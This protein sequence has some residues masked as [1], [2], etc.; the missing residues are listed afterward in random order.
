MS[1]DNNKNRDV[2]AY[3]MFSLLFDDG[4]FTEFGTKVM[5]CDNLAEGIIACGKV[6][7]RSV[8]AFAQDTGSCGG[9]LSVAQANKFKK[10]YSLALKTGYPIVGIYSDSTA[11]VTQGNMLLDAVG[12]VL[13][14]SSRLSGVVPMVSLVLGS[15][16]GVSA[17][18]ASNADFVVMTEDAKLSVSDCSL[19]SGKGK[20]AYVAKDAESAAKAVA[21]LV[22]YLPSNNL[23]VAPLA[24]NFTADTDSVFD[25]DSVLRLYTEKESAASVALARLAGK[26]VGCVKTTGQPIDSKSC[27]KIAAFVRF[28]DAYSIPVITEVNSPEFECLGGAKTVLSAY[29][30]ATTIKISVITGKAVGVGYLALAGKGARADVILA[31]Q[32]AV[33]SPVKP[34]VAAFIALG[35]KLDVPVAQQDELISQYIAN[36]L[37]AENAAKE[38]FIDNALEFSALRDELINY[39]EILSGKRESSLP[40]KHNTI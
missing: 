40:K 7:G 19:C 4:N 27:K 39:L 33:I 13:C 25:K 26:V 24:E 16:I 31:T 15:C 36:E 22:S 12:D 29:S 37:S 32:G 1:I 23:S 10:L 2:S 35:D 5:S 28:C 30:E 20:A 14:A 18:M 38:G 9:A 34:E 3:S 11:K 6:F 21:Q 8:Y 17:L